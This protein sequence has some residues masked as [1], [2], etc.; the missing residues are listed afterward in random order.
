MKLDIYKY[1]TIPILEYEIDGVMGI[2]HVEISIEDSNID[3]EKALKKAHQRNYPTD[4]SML[5]LKEWAPNTE[6]IHM[7]TAEVNNVSE[8]REVFTNTLKNLKTTNP[9]LYL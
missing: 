7:V 6:F 8:I 4:P 9:E 3:T 5:S 1:A 2:A